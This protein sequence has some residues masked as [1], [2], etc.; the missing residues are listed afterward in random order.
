MMWIAPQNLQPSSLLCISF[1]LFGFRNYLYVSKCSTIKLE[2]FCE[3]HA[4]NCIYLFS[5]L[6]LLPFAIRKL[7]VLDIRLYYIKLCSN[8][9][10][11]VTSVA[12]KR[13]EFENI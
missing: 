13:A 12:L 6:R 11:Y 3:I 9:M 1:Y 5:Q 4:F 8:R 10:V 2:G 7:N